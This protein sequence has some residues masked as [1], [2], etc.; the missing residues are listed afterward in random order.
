MYLLQ[1]TAVGESRTEMSDKITPWVVFGLLIAAAIG[2]GAVSRMIFTKSNSMSTLFIPFADLFLGLFWTVKYYPGMIR[3]VLLFLFDNSITTTRL[4][5]NWMPWIQLLN[6]TS[7]IL[8]DLY[9]V[10]AAT[11]SN[12]SIMALSLSFIHLSSIVGLYSG[13]HSYLLLMAVSFQLF[14]LY[15]F[16]M[17]HLLSSEI[18]DIDRAWRLVSVSLHINSAG[19]FLFFLTGHRFEFSKLQVHL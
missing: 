14:F 4:L 5:L 16:A 18:K 9:E 3:P 17:R 11:N 13:P 8:V 12:S 6:F 2:K 1:G 15:S 19:R 7:A 10:C